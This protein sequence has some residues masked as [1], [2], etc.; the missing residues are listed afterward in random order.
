M[1]SR[2]VEAPCPPEAGSRRRDK[3]ATKAALLAAGV[4]VFAERGCDAATTREVAQVA[5]VNE[6]LIQRYFG[7][8]SGLLLAIIGRFGE[9]EQRCC[10]LPPP[11]AGVEA[12]IRGFLEYQLARACEIGDFTRVALQRSLCDPA[13]AR[14]IGRH[15]A[16]TRLPLLRQRLDAL[17]AQKLID[18]EVDLEAAATALASLSFGLGFVDQLVFGADCNQLRRVV[19]H[20]ARTYARGLAPK[21]PQPD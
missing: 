20:V 11:C 2:T 1:A 15:F 14:E 3:E 12:E 18:P 13:V 21:P 6:Q 9:E 8:K 16:E 10:A 4:Q 17:R 19:R 7:G 5:G